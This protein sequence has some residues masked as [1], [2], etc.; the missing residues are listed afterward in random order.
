MALSRATL[1]T[2]SAL[3]LGTRSFSSGQ[4][5]SGPHVWV[6][7]DTRV[8]CQGMTGKQVFCF[9]FLLLSHARAVF[10]LFFLFLFL[11]KQTIKPCPT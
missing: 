9:V 5:L 7:K 2:S 4:T 3:R 6:D 8:I 10:F 1:L 11:K